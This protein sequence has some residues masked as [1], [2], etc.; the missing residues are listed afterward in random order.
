MP[1]GRYPGGGS[2]HQ[3]GVAG[4]QQYEALDIS[5]LG[6]VSVQAALSVCSTAWQSGSAP[7]DQRGQRDHTDPV[8]RR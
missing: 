6:F 3:A 4:I 2:P 5:S 7:A 8:Y 1:S